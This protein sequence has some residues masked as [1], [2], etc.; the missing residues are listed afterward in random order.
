MT[1]EG[2]TVW[3]RTFADA[4]PA[5]C[6]YACAVTYYKAPTWPRL[7]PWLFLVAGALVLASR[8]L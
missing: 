7:L 2:C 3:P 6:D 1:R 5:S 8:F 4:F